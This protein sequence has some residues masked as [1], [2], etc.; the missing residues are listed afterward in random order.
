MCGRINVSQIRPDLDFLLP[1]LIQVT[2]SLS[3]STCDEI[4]KILCNKPARPPMVSTLQ[5]RW[6]TTGAIPPC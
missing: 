1:L 3:Q 6:A 5:Q 2:K 4:D